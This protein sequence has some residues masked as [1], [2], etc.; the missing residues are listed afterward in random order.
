[1]A[2]R[3]PRPTL[4]GA[5]R[6]PERVD[7]ILGGDQAVTFA[8]VTPLLG[9]VLTP[10]TNTG[11]RDREAGTFTPVSS[12]VG[13]WKKLKRITE[14]PRVAVAYHARE[15]GFAD[16]PEYVV[17]QG[18]A[19]LTPIEDRNWVE[20]HLE[21]WERFS[22]PRKVG[23]IGERWLSAYHWRVGIE[24][25]VE[26][27]IVW[28]DLACRDEPEVYGKALPTQPP[29]P[30]R[31][32]RNG[33]GPRINDRRAA[34]RAARLPNRLLGWVGTD[35]FPMIVPVEIAGTE[36]QGVILELPHGVAVP[37]GGRRAGLTAHSFARYTFGQNQRKYT[38]WM[39]PDPGKRRALY[40]PHTEAGYR[41]PESRLLYRIG[42]GLLTRR[43]LREARKAGFIA[44]QAERSAN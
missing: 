41:L 11:L 7:L 29:A 17:A 8:H 38:G 34:K 5:V 10:L 24:I 3:L 13:M 33:T 43:G 12:S 36:K 37:P 42:A 14:E 6:W 15:H 44:S 1:M 27:L 21:N 39:V 18:M 30:Q 26:R 16:R 19:S 40:A 9:V 31:P 22:G 32:P 35:G 25:A 20:Q 4:E 28:A 2:H 23:P